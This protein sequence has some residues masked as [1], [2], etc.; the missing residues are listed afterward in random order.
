M[1]VRHE[2]KRLADNRNWAVGAAQVASVV[3]FPILEAVLLKNQA[4][5]GGLFW[6]IG[7]PV[8]IL[9]LASGLFVFLAT[10]NEA[11]YFKFEDA[12]A[13]IDDLEGVAKRL[14]QKL[15]EERE[16]REDLDWVHETNYLALQSLHM[17]ISSVD[18]SDTEFLR[19]AVEI[20]LEPFIHNREQVFGFKSCARHNISVYLY[21][22]DSQH[23][24]P[25]YR[26]VDDRISRSDRRWKPGNGHI[27]ICF[28]QNRMIVSS[29]VSKS[30]LLSDS[31]TVADMSNYQ[32]MASIPIQ[33]YRSL[34]KKPA[35]SNPE[36]AEPRGVFIVTSSEGNQLS[37]EAHEITL[38]IIASL[39]STLF[40]YAD[41]LNHSK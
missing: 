15:D 37:A 21:E 13:K 27:G 29:D 14:S 31:M 28:S 18:L 16:Q 7:V 22:P 19:N 40:D 24:A 41:L 20:I 39:L 23:L 10:R 2:A 33:S 30:P 6:A 9:H 5:L 12:Q 3:V 17:L 11:F 1:D 25:Y 32:S 36:T 34:G 26:F 38:G 8:V 35:S 4:S